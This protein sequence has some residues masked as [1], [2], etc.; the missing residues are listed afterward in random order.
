M[1][2][3]VERLHVGTP[4]RHYVSST[5]LGVARTCSLYKDPTQV[6]QRLTKLRRV[7]VGGSVDDK[8]CDGLS[9]CR[10]GEHRLRRPQQQYGLRLR[11]LEPTSQTMVS[12]CL[13]WG[14]MVKR[15]NDSEVAT[16]FR[17]FLFRK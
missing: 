17:R 6:Q 15:R 3:R 16:V 7:A 1:F 5:F 11:D 9:L 13:R 2:E 4:F 12:N 14:A 8:H 10:L